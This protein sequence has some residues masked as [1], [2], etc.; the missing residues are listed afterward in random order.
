M[1]IPASYFMD[2]DKLV[3][4][5]IWK[6]KRT[7]IVNTILKDKNK[8]GRLTLSDFKPYYKATVIKTM[9]YW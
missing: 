8:V 7:R 9:W 6:G 1:K 5:S 2:I 3:I 4:K